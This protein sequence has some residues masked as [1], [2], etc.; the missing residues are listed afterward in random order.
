MNKAGTWSVDNVIAATRKDTYVSVK[1]VDFT[2]CDK[3]EM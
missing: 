3:S 2:V 1:C